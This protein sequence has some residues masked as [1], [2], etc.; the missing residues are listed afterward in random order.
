MTDT[1]L[2]KVTNEYNAS[3]G[4]LE[5]QSTTEGTITS[6][7]NTLGQFV[8]S[9]DVSGN[10]AKYVYEEGGDGRPFEVSE[11]KGAEAKSSQALVLTASLAN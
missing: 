11:G 7:N 5:K 2:P 8:E 1:A 10:V 9:T 4:A 6:K 3:T